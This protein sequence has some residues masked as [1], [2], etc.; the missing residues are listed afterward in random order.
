MLRTV[1]SRPSSP[2][3]SLPS[4]VD[5]SSCPVAT[6]IPIAIGRSNAVPSFL[7]SA[8]ARL[9]VILRGGSLNPELT[10]AAPTRSLLS[11]TAPMGN[12]TIVHCGKPAAASTSTM[13]SY[14]SI[15]MSAAER[16]AAS[17]R[18]RH[19]VYTFG[20]HQTAARFISFPRKS[21]DLL[22]TDEPEW[23]PAAYNIRM[24]R[25]AGS[26]IEFH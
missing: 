13:M 14:A 6:R 18:Q 9:I 10:S 1:P 16:T 25:Q 5:G 23:H 15:P 3:K 22:R 26:Q 2:T 21:R 8:G 12:P 17:M 11:F 19:L 24:N 4:S 7:T 20:A